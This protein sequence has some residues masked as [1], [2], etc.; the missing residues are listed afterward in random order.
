MEMV[1]GESLITSHGWVMLMRRIVPA[2]YF[3]GGQGSLPHSITSY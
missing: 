3:L 2:S 1:A